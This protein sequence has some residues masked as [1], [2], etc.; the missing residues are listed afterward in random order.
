MSQITYDNDDFYAGYSQLPRS[1]EGLT[2]APECPSVRALLPALKGAR[3]L[4]L[5]CRFGAL[6]VREAVIPI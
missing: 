4:D 1:V 3:V 2:A 5:G 6:F